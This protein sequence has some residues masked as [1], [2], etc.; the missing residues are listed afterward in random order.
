MGGFR[1]A[2]PAVA[3][4]QFD[5]P[6]APAYADHY[7][8]PEGGVEESRAVFL[9][10]NRIQER[11]TTPH[12]GRLLI[13]ETGFGT[14]LNFLNT[15]QIWAQ[16]APPDARLHFFS[17]EAHP[18][19]KTDLRRALTALGVEPRWRD[20]LCTQ[21]PPP[22]SGIHRIRFEPSEICTSHAGPVVLD[23][24]FLD[25]TEGLRQIPDRVRFDAWYLD[26]FA[27]ARNPDMWTL[28][29]FAQLARLSAPGTTFGTFSAAGA[30]RRGLQAVGFAVSKASGFGAKRE[31]LHGQFVGPQPVVGCSADPRLGVES[32]F[33]P[34][35]RRRVCVI[36][37]GIAGATT[38]R[39]LAERGIE[40]TVLER[41]QI[42]AGASKL[43]QAVLYPR[44]HAEA[45]PF[46]MA[47]LH[48]H[49][50]SA[51]QLERWSTEA[52]DPCYFPTGV[53]QV[54]ASAEE[55]SKA[56]A[57]LARADLSSQMAVWLGASE[58]SA[59]VGAPL[60]HGG[61]WFPNAGW[62][63]LSLLCCRLLTH[64]RIDVRIDANVGALTPSSDTST[65]QVL[66]RQGQ[67]LAA[68]PVVVV[69]TA[70]EAGALD[71]CRFLPLQP[72]AG[73]VTLAPALEDSLGL[74]AVLCGSG[75]LL[76][77]FHGQHA[78]GATYRLGAVDP[79]IS[80]IDHDANL[81]AAKQDFGPLGAALQRPEIRASVQGETGVRATLPDRLPAVGAV[82][83]L[84]AYRSRFA[85]LRHNA[86]E[87]VRAVAPMLPGLF[88][89]AGHGSKGLSMAP[90]AAELLAAY[91]THEPFPLTCALAEA[92]A[93]VRFPMRALIRG[94][95]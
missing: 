54:A 59:R 7:F 55:A 47:H 5:T 79:A 27:P 58:A 89:N 20:A 19:A 84:D 28:D 44:V 67:L 76:P 22:I 75:Y 85:P 78:L 95:D 64:P 35:V 25:A 83:D 43:S 12:A 33:A 51:R 41:K 71:Q 74:K 53:L 70:L 87:P 42:A 50:F 56:Q 46:A 8:S 48:A 68:A 60:E 18:L 10:P 90:L 93:P 6:N 31:R 36:G 16:S 14:G 37:A 9:R 15:V 57:K 91:L 63:R 39:A 17:L 94:R 73:Q 77:A 61:V 30:V 66:D 52:P 29:L 65:W 11:C 3:W 24:G 69:A 13:G 4:D 49:L 21:Y 72:I 2:H 62:V 81:A 92:V 80:E 88:V 26:G 38:A 23:L 1:V 32:S 86:R 40:V 82:P 45:S 34:S